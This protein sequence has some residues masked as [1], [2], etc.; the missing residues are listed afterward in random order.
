MIAGSR[1]GRWTQVSGL[2]KLALLTLRAA[3]MAASLVLVVAIGVVLAG[4]LP[5]FFGAE[6]FTVYSGSMEPAIHVGDLAVVRPSKTSD[7][8]PGD[9]I[10]YRT[11]QRPDTLVTHRLVG[12]TETG[13][14]QR[15]FRTKGDANAVEDV[16][17]TDQGAVL[18]KVVYAV[19]VAGYI[20]EFSRSFSGRLVLIAMPA[21]LLGVDFLRRR[22]LR[23]ERQRELASLT[24]AA[25]QGDAIAQEQ[26]IRLL[27]ERGRQASAAGRADLAARA[28][29]GV[30]GLDPR[31]VDAW[32]LRIETA[33]TPEE[34]EALLQTALVLNPNAASVQALAAPLRRAADDRASSEQRSSDGGQSRDDRRAG[35]RGGSRQGAA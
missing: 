13:D 17:L 31:N 14:G 23:G 7:L 34:R 4:V 5:T 25:D 32:V 30:L 16:V 21:V 35:A 28:A 12:I 27:L 10:T 26:R 20:V 6:S 9:I 18:G 24:L 8:K 11:P 22:V 33:G 3:Q 19:P 2:A 29:E 15:Q 1:S